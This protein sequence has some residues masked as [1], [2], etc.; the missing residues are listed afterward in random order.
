[1]GKPY[2]LTKEIG[3]SLISEYLNT[4]VT[5]VELSKRYKIH[6]VTISTFF[7]VNGILI[8]RPGAMPG[9][10]VYDG[11]RKKF[12]KIHKNNKYTVGRKQS[13]TTKLK[14]IA[15]NSGLPIDEII[16]FKDYQKFK[17]IVSWARTKRTLFDQSPESR[18]AFVNHFY[19]DL[20]FNKIWKNWVDS[21]KRHLWKPSIDHIVPFSKGGTGCI[22]NLQVITWFENKIKDSMT[23]EEW[24][25]FKLSTNTSSN[26]FIR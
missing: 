13:D 9:H 18:L 22:Q 10:K 24:S 7:K 16:K 25:D 26:L 1:M 21:G 12:S 23:E 15:T 20:Q 4:S 8:K 6:K 11:T 19:Y 17:L 14:L 2:K 3:D 5:L